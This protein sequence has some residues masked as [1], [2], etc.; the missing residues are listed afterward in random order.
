M[1]QSF[2]SDALST[3]LIFNGLKGEVID[4]V[5]SS[6]HVNIK[7]IYLYF[8][9][10]ALQVHCGNAYN[11]T[12]HDS[13]IH[14]HKLR[15][16]GIYHAKFILITTT[17]ACRFI[18]MTTNITEQLVKNCLNDYYM[19]TVPKVKLSAPTDF[20]I[21]LYQFLD[22]FNIKLK[23][24]LNLYNWKGI[25][26]NLLISVPTG[27]NHALCWRTIIN[28]PKRV[29]GSAVIRTTTGMLGFDIKKVL[30]VQECIFEY[31]KEYNYLY[32]SFYLHYI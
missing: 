18:V 3:D 31:Q 9:H 4:Y 5:I 22:A 20:T 16:P 17:E 29:R 32:Q 13:F 21:R 1:E 2:T 28:T 26:A 10:P 6:Y 19:I 25:Q 24:G 8:Y 27:L 12:G 14:I 30:R 11:G 23:S 15:E 7:L